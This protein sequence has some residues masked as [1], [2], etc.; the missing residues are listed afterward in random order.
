ML[1]ETKPQTPFQEKISSLFQQSLTEEQRFLQGIL[2]GE[3]QTFSTN[4]DEIADKFLDEIVR[5]AEKL[6][7]IADAY[8]DGRFHVFPLKN[9]HSVKFLVVGSY[10]MI[11]AFLPRGINH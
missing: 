11:A 2:R 7:F 8:A 6:S 9:G 1:N 3:I 10:I 4:S 5:L